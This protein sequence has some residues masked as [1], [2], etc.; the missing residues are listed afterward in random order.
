MIIV[1]IEDQVEYYEVHPPSSLVGMGVNAIDVDFDFTV[2]EDTANSVF[3]L[4]CPCSNTMFE[5]SCWVDRG[6]V[7]PPI[8]V[9]CTSCGRQHIIHDPAIHG[10]DA[11]LGEGEPW[12][13]SPSAF[14]GP[15]GNDEDIEIP[16]QIF[17]RYEYPA[18]VLEDGEY[19]GR[20]HDLYTMITI[21]AHDPD[22]GELGL[23]YEEDCS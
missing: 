6:E 23:M 3:E 4:V 12:A 21:L 7:A 19:D 5:A 2:R 16:H 18:D 14:A 9:L 15:L 11:H 10:Y 20:E 17:L 13:P 8:S 22:T 1:E